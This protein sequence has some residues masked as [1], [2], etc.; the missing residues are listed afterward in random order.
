[1]N[2]D[3]TRWPLYGETVD[4]FRSRLHSHWRGF[5]AFCPPD[6]N[7][8]LN[9]ASFAIIFSINPV[10]TSRLPGKASLGPPRGRLLLIAPA[11]PCCGGAGTDLRLEVASAIALGMSPVTTLAQISGFMSL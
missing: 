3:F 6:P 9:S 7:L 10:E 8:P 5:S 2:H 11:S 1:M 4:L